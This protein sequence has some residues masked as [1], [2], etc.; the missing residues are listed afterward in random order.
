V[1]IYSHISDKR[2]C[3]NRATAAVGDGEWQ[4]DKGRKG[5]EQTEIIEILA[6]QNAACE[7]GSVGREMIGSA[8]RRSLELSRTIFSPATLD[9]ASLRKWQVSASSSKLSAD[10]CREETSESA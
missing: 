1:P 4:S 6:D 9:Y 7:K 10:S 8:M 5:R 3:A 2:N